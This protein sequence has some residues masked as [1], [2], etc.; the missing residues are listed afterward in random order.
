MTHIF[1]NHTKNLLLT[2]LESL[3]NITHLQWKISRKCKIGLNS[4]ESSSCEGSSVYFTVY[5]RPTSAPTGCDGFVVNW[6]VSCGLLIS[7]FHASSSMVCGTLHLVFPINMMQSG[8]GS[9]GGLF[10]QGSTEK[11]GL[12]NTT[13]LEDL[14]ISPRN[15]IY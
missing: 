13:L 12:I 1:I 8:R 10:S 14:T 7:L 5:F 3:F 4:K 9:G 6:F 2:I 11:V 15:A